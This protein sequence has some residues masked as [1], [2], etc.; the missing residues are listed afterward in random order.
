MEYIVSAL[1]TGIFMLLAIK[2]NKLKATRVNKFIPKLS[3]SRTLSMYYQPYYSIPE[4]I[5][6]QASKY[7]DRNKLKIAMF[8]N[9]AY[10]IKDQKV[11]AAEIVDGNIDHD[12][13]KLIDTMAMSGV[14][15]KKFQSIIEMLTEGHGNDSRSSGN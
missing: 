3:Q 13:A 11:W 6:T 1:I 14:E 15:L 9:K 7:S 12:T 4:P 2:F 8:E 5:R 10:W